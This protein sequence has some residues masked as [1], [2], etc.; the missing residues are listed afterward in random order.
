[1]CETNWLS[2][3]WPVVVLGR[4]G[5]NPS[6]PMHFPQLNTNQERPNQTM[7]MGRDGIAFLMLMFLLAFI[8]SKLTSLILAIALL[9][10][11]IVVGKWLLIFLKGESKESLRETINRLNTIGFSFTEIRVP[12]KLRL[13]EQLIMT[14]MTNPGDDYKVIMGRFLTSI[15]MH[16]GTRHYPNYL[17]NGL[18]KKMMWEYE[19][20]V[21]DLNVAPTRTD[22]PS[23]DEIRSPIADA[24]KL[25][26]AQFCI[27]H[28]M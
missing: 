1:M 9:I 22:F 20:K 2:I 4:L 21:G 16:D 11:T 14:T 7:T 23:F 27:K 12:S 15:N 6:L 25:A 3:S 28:T 8:A 24:E 19:K 26:F 18:V 5:A 13:I 10:G 17:H